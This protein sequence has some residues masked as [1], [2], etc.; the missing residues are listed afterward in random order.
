MSNGN[1]S[2]IAWGEHW[3]WKKKR[4]E[5]PQQKFMAR[6]GGTFISALSDQLRAKPR[7]RQSQVHSF[8]MS[9]GAQPSPSQKDEE[10]ACC[11]AG[12]DQMKRFFGMSRSTRITI[13]KHEEGACCAAGCNQVGRFFGMSGSTRTAITPVDVQA[14]CYKT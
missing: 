13:A 7:G 9:T 3:Q 12:C 10:G 14:L 11:A 8:G 1:G 6:R 5:P 4:G 2:D